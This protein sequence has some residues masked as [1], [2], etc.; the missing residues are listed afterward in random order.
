MVRLT[1]Y[2]VMA[3]NHMYL[4]RVFI[5]N[6]VY[7]VFTYIFDIFINK[8]YRNTFSTHFSIF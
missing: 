1:D 2:G 4:I 3:H 8:E 5:L 6:D 7:C